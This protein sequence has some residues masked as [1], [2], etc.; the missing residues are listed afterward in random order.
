MSSRND[1][2]ARLEELEQSASAVAA[3]RIQL[4]ED[5]FAHEFWLE[6]YS[7]MNRSIGPVY[8]RYHPSCV[9]ALRFK[10]IYILCRIKKITM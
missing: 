4:I 9:G 1:S 7:R 10:C 6:K 5:V 8:E 3:R 2:S